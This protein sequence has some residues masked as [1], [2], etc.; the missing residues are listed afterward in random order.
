VRI[1][2]LSLLLAPAVLVA[3]N[4]PQP[5]PTCDA[6]AFRAFDYWVGEW[7]V[8]DSTGKQIAE[9]S[10]SLVAGD[11]AVLEQWHPVGSPPGASISWWD[12][13]DSLWHQSWMSGTGRA[14]QYVGGP[15]DG[16]M[17]M[18]AKPSPQV[19][20]KMTWVKRPGGVVRQSQFVSKDQ[21]ATWQPGFVGD[22]S[23]RR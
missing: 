7:T 22:Y 4:P 2:L 15:E 23:P 12:R 10:I 11:C 21:G 16:V 5:L 13:S 9:S 14:T 1:A 19:W 18:V 8:A 20:L 6:P 17:T 3:Q